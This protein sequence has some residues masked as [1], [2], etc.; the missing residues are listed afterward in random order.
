MSLAALAPWA[1]GFACLALVIWRA[2]R[3]TR[4]MVEQTLKR[5]PNPTEAEFLAEMSPEISRPTAAFLWETI[6]P[7]VAPKLTPHPDDHL[8][9]DLPIDED[10]VTMDWPA[11]FAKLHGR[12]IELWPDWPKDCV[13]TIRNFGRWLDSGLD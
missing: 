7:Y 8:W 2:V 6:A 11:N 4:K 5:R 12:T 10:D 3:N 1:F 13:P 9:R